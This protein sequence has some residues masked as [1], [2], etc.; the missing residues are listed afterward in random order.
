LETFEQQNLCTELKWAEQIHKDKT[1][2]SVAKGM[3]CMYYLNSKHGKL[4]R[5]E[6]LISGSACITSATLQ[7]IPL[8]REHTLD[9]AKAACQK[10]YDLINNISLLHMLEGSD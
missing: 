1:M 6:K 4:I 9:Q 7:K 2:L 5:M 10:E 3:Q 8:T